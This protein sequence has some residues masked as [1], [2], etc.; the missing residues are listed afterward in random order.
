MKI[1]ILDTTL[2]DGTQG[3]GVSFS[4]EDR[5]NVIRAL[6]ALGISYIEA[7][8][9]TDDA[10]REFFDSLRDVR[11]E[12]AKLCVF[13][14]TAHPGVAAEKSDLL[15]GAAAAPVPCAVLYGKSSLYQVRE[16]LRTTPEENLRMIRDS[17]RF[18]RSAGKEV[19]FDAEH[20]FDGYGDG[21]DYV[22]S[23][24]DAAL[25][26]GASRVI[27][28]DTNGGMLPD[29]IGMTVERVVRSF[30]DIGIHCHNDMGMAVSGSVSAVLAGA[31]QVQGTVSGIGERC[32]NANLNTLIPLLQLKLGFDCVGDRLRT[33]TPTVKYINE[34][35]NLT[36]DETEP[37]VGAYA[38]THKAGT[39][40]DGV[41]KDP[42]TF[43][44]VD[45]ESVGNL[46]N[47]VISELSGRAAVMDKI[48]DLTGRKYD[49]AGKEDPRIL[50]AIQA[51]RKKEKNGYVYEQAEGSLALMI[52]RVMG[53]DVSH[54]DLLE[55]KVIAED[56]KRAEEDGEVMK[57]S[58]MIKI[59]VDGS[60]EIAAAEGNGPVNA[61]DRALRRALTRFYPEVSKMKLT[62]YRVRVIDSGATASSVRVLI[63]ST[64]GVSVW[65][66][67]GVSTDIINASW[68]ALRDSV[69]YM[70]SHVSQKS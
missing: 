1:E 67:V 50:E 21:P 4:P 47:T 12:S 6:D 11:T 27:L 5:I 41:K 22:L 19:L 36:F 18:L 45:P 43:E 20:F 40:I 70:L 42:R 68:Q 9:V 33:L 56:S 38:F 64:D 8:M 3:A 24:V 46:R 55:F 62:D 49:S 31:R 30:P 52:D 59:S 15:A 63:E 61:M 25:E 7:G 28:C 13:S 51:L 66:T 29:V 32:G 34:I 53:E 10:G 44:H 58:A 14:P 26:A 39:H 23:V 57:S 60:D 17:I 65:R 37:F 48:A 16:V 54:F 69:E 2:R 35:A